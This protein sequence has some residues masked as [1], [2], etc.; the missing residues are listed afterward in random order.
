MMKIVNSL[1]L[2]LDTRALFERAVTG[3]SASRSRDIWEK[4]LDYENQYGDI[5]NAG[6]VFQ[7]V[8][9]IYPD[10]ISSGKNIYYLANRWK[11]LNLNVVGDVELGLGQGEST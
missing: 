7:R 8:K 2:I 9:E 10:D 11:V 5:G 3:I 4:W 1:Y 6:R